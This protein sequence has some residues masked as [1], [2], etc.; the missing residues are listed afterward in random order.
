[1]TKFKEFLIDNE[2]VFKTVAATGLTLMSLVVAIGQTV[3]AREQLVLVELQAKISKANASP[4]LEVA[5]HQKLNDETG[6]FDDNYIEINNHGGPLYDFF[7]EPMYFLRIEANKMYE[8]SP[9]NNIFMSQIGWTTIE[10]PVNGYFGTQFVSSAPKGF[11]TTISGYH[12]NARYSSLADAVRQ[13]ATE[14]VWVSFLLNERY[15]VRLRYRDMLDQ[16]HE[17]VYEVPSVG[18]GR[19]LPDE[20]GSKICKEWYGNPIKSEL[21]KINAEE[22]I[23]KIAERIENHER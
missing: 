21:T 6:K 14:P 10:I 17:E 4:V 8:K 7:A 5:L 23:A 11:L 3:T 16:T 20:D 1:M 15:Y 22:L 2:I 13:I 18:A 12:N 19:R 9:K